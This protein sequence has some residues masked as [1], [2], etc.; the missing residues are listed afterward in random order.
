M[1]FRIPMTLPA[2][3]RTSFMEKQRAS[4]CGRLGCIVSDMRCSGSSVTGA[5]PGITSALDDGEP[6]EENKI[7]RGPVVF[8]G[9]DCLLTYQIQKS[10][11]V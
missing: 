10:G 8:P 1:K 4:L 7:S 9:S 6:K 2:R 3:Y 11:L 5:D